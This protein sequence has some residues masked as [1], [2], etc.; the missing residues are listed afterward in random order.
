M[1]DITFIRNE[2]EGFRIHHISEI[3]LGQSPTLAGG[4]IVPNK[5]DHVIDDTSGFSKT[6]RVNSITADLV[7]VLTPLY[8]S[9]L[10]A[11]NSNDV[12]NKGLS[13]NSVVKNVVYVDTTGIK[14]RLTTEHTQYVY[15]E[16]FVACKIFLGTDTSEEGEVISQ[17][18]NPEGVVV[19]N[20][21]QLEEVSDSPNTP[22]VPGNSVRGI[23]RV[24]VTV[25]DA[26]NVTEGSLVTIVYYTA[27]NSS[28]SM[29]VFVVSLTDAIRDTNYS[30]LAVQSIDLV[31]PL[32]ADIGGYDSAMILNDY[33]VP[34]A[35]NS[36]QCDVTYTDGSVVRLDVD[37]VKIRLIGI[38]EF[39]HFSL[40]QPTSLT[41][42]YYPS[43]N[44]AVI[45]VSGTSVRVKTKR[46][47]LA[48]NKADEAFALKVFIEPVWGG[49][50]V[51]YTM[52][53]WV[54][55]DENSFM[56][57]PA[58]SNIFLEGDGE[59]TANY[60]PRLYGTKQHLLL[61]LN[62][63]NQLPGSYPT[64]PMTQRVAI[65]LRSPSN[66]EGFDPWV[67][68]Y[69]TDG[70]GALGLKS[71]IRYTSS[72]KTLDF[73]SPMGEYSNLEEMLDAL[74]EPSF[75]IF[76]P[77]LQTNASKPTHIRLEIEGFS[78]TMP[79]EKWASF[80]DATGFPVV[81][82]STGRLVWLLRNK[83]SDPFKILS[84][85]PLMV[86]TTI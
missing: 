78:H 48:N 67:I 33:G 39:D 60:N 56:V 10:Q 25:I 6:Y 43:P 27:T 84:T 83:E 36:L 71:R 46:Y 62:V 42:A 69:P 5:G 45:G 64:H 81:N 8:S 76:D 59:N 53:Y 77:T 34:F 68:D 47:L 72:N 18:F 44:E 66:N 52:R 29:D 37:G 26:T 30:T 63:D 40:G 79:V 65:T 58:G 75:P 57:E 20:V 15:G 4:R 51:G 1:S 86:K 49:I 80:I 55:N 32:V 41:L 12:L 16:E 38:N 2:N 85:T 61:R 21:I 74:Y 73:R 35:T 50:A 7:A 82:N 11:I 54:L 28:K 23:K 9:D 70:T 24:P 17:R 14:A 19:S 22:P 13:N 31:S 3:Y